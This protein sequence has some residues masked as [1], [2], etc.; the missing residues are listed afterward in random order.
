MIMNI[1]TC[2][3]NNTLIIKVSSQR[4]TEFEMIHGAPF[5]EPFIVPNS[6]SPIPTATVRRIRVHILKDLR[7]L[8]LRVEPPLRPGD[9]RLLVRRQRLQVCFETTDIGAEIE[10]IGRVQKRQR[11]VIPTRFGPIFHKRMV[12][13][14]DVGQK[15]VAA[16][17]EIL[18]TKYL[19]KE[20]WYH[21]GQ[22]FPMVILV[23]M[24]MVKVQFKAIQRGPL[25]GRKIT[26]EDNTRSRISR[27]AF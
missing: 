6:I 18:F 22:N 15:Q 23:N 12:M 24:H 2:L 20:R 14:H 16:S 26:E 1:L 13:N 21:V 3:T 19:H 11:S 4:A 7:K 25:F 8:P 9:I 10:S 17:S 27:N 5:N